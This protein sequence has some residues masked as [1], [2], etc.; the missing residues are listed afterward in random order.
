MSKRPRSIDEIA[1]QVPLLPLSGALL[2]P[3]TQ[4][5]LNI[6][7]PRYIRLIDDL[8][9][10]DRLVGIIQPEDDDMES[11]RANDAPLKNVGCLGYLRAFE[12][13]DDERYL[14][15]LEGICRFDLKT[16]IK[17]TTPYRQAEIALSSYEADLDPA[18]D[19]ET[20]DREEFLDLMRAYSE[21]AEFEFDWD[22]IRDIQTTQLVNM[23]CVLSPYGATE[24]Q[25]LLEATNLNIRAQT[26]IALA[27]MEMASARG[28]GAGLQ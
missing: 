14:I 24:K 27:E 1:P 26:L 18:T 22:G 8:L 19:E 12:E 16:E 11:P 15:V 17:V 25:A 6:F 23:C 3:Q 4:R 20:V 7:E 13:Q 2:L 10:Q 28:S 21:F 5:P 9:A